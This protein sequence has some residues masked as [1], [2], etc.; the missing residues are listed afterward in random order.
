M[1][2]FTHQPEL[3]PALHRPT[4]KFCFSLRGAVYYIEC[5]KYERQPPCAAWLQHFRYAFPVLLLC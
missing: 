1:L 5:N 2:W 4:V 3:Q